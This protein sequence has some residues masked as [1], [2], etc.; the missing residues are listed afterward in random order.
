MRP[1]DRRP[2]AL[3]AIIAGMLTW[4]WWRKRRA[5]R[6]VFRRRVVLI[7]GGSRGLG[8]AMARRAA[9]LAANVVICGRDEYALKRAAN[10]LERLGAEVLAV[11]CDVGDR[12]EVERLVQTVVARFGPIDVLINNA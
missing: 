2:L 7:T 3:G 5:L 11:P 8:L 10:D 4:R 12:G 1:E 9:R 6:K